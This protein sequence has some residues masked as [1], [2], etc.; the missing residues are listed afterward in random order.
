MTAT[1]L[2]DKVKEKVGIE[3]KAHEAQDNKQLLFKNEDHHKLEPDDRHHSQPQS[4]PQRL[5]RRSSSFSLS[6]SDGVINF[7]DAD[8]SYTSTSNH[9]DWESDHPGHR[10]K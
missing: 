10:K 3:T 4:R 1:Q 7:R 8:G 9:N 6:M 2:L 5:E